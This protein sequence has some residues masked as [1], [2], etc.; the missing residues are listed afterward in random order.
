[1][2]E[3]TDK[4]K[5][6][7]ENERESLSQNLDEIEYRFKDATDLKGHFDRNTGLIL[8]AAVAGGFLCSLV[9][10]RSS[11]NSQSATTNS[12]SNA[13]EKTATAPTRSERFISEHLSGVSETVND[14]AAGLA[15]L[16]S[17]KLQSIISKAVPGFREQYENIRQRAVHSRRSSTG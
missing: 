4:I 16:F 17:E 15:G 8:G 10:G 13:Q 12:P 2:V 5:Q 6:H 3:D 7:I 9:L 14:I 1:V 11:R